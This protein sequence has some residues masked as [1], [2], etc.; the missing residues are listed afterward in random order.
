MFENI[1]HQ[2]S[3]VGCARHTDA[4]VWAVTDVGMR[5]PAAWGVSIASPESIGE[6]CAVHTLRD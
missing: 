4:N 1:T 2:H 3:A 5:G 6:R